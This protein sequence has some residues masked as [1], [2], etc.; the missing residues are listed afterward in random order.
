METNILNTLIDT[1]FSGIVSGIIVAFVTNYM[2]R[3]KT[4]TEIR[5]MEAHTEKTRLE[6]EQLRAQVQDVRTRIRIIDRLKLDDNRSL[7]LKEEE[8]TIQEVTG[9]RNR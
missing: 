8:R 3:R 2:N 7:V 9:E 1:L 5:Q 4:E 6:I